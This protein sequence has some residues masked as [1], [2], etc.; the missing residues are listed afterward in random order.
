MSKRFLVPILADSLRHSSHI[1]RFFYSLLVT[2]HWAIADLLLCISNC[3]TKTSDLPYRY[4]C[5]LVPYIIFL[6]FYS[7]S[8]ISVWSLCSIMASIVICLFPAS[9]SPFIISHSLS[10]FGSLPWPQLIGIF[11]FEPWSSMTWFPLS[12]ALF[13]GQYKTCTQH[14]IVSKFW[15]VFNYLKV[16]ADF[17]WQLGTW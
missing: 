4:E 6:P 5:L 12:I 16:I 10:F 13:Y 15:I 14:F 8:L 3:S 17:H 7:L 9:H 1:V 11:F 2:K